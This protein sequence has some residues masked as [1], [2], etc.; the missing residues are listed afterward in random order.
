[1]QRALFVGNAKDG[2]DLIL[3]ARLAR[4]IVFL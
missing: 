1:M 2:H 3:L 4:R